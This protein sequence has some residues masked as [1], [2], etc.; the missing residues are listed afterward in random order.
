MVKAMA[1]VAAQIPAPA[2]HA[3]QGRDTVPAMAMVAARRF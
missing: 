1:I 3:R 2:R